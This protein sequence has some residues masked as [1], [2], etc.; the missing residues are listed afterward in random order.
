MGRTCAKVIDGQ[1]FG[2]HE[3][4]D[5]IVYKTLVALTP[6][7]VLN[8][9]SHTSTRLLTLRQLSVMCIDC[10]EAQQQSDN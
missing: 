6:G 10:R 4:I 8:R 2:R 3:I 1:V 5:D 9:T 7:K